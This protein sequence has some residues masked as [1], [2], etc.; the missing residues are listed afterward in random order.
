MTSEK[1]FKIT[2][3][4]KGKMWWYSKARGCAYRRPQ[5]EYTTKEEVSSPT[6]SL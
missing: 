5:Q 6:V 1:S 4:P 3:V 2:Y